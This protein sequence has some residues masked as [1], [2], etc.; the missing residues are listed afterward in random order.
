MVRLKR[1]GKEIF[2]IRVIRKHGE[3]VLR[4][5]TLMKG[6]LKGRYDT[7]GQIKSMNW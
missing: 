4:I 2:R 6:G 7:R 1:A 3:K 5:C